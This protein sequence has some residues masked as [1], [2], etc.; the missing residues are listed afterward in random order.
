MSIKMIIFCLI[1]LFTIVVIKRHDGF[2]YYY[3]LKKKKK[4]NLLRAGLSD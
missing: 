4:Y 2:H 1:A 3:Y